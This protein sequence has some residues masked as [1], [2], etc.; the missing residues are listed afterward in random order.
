MGWL[1]HITT[2]GCAM[3][4][5]DSQRLASR[6]NELG[7]SAT[8]QRSQ[9][10]LA[11]LVT[12]GVRQSAEDRIYGLIKRIKQDNPQTAVALTGCLSYRPDIQAKIGQQVDYWFTINQLTELEQIIPSPQPASSLTHLHDYLQIKP[13]YTSKISALVPIGNGCDNFCSYCVVPYARGREKYRPADEIIAEVQN[14]LAADSQEITIIAQNVNSYRDP[15]SGLNF[16]GLLEQLDSLG[17]YWLRFA[18]SHPKDMSDELIAFMGRSRNLIHHLHLPVQSG[19]DRILQLMNRRYTSDHYRQ[20]I[21]A[22]RQVWPDVSLTTDIIVGFPGETDTDFQATAKLVTAS[23][24]DQVY[25]AQFSPRPGTA[26]A[27]LPDDVPTA[28]KKQR[29]I[30]LDQLVKAGTL[31]NRQAQIG[32]TVEVLLEEQRGH[33]YFGRTNRNQQILLI[34]QTGNNYVLGQRYLAQV[35]AARNFSLAGQLL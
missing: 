29:A 2:I 25:I 17:N 22:V 5:S 24:F 7:W 21:A 20:L 18:T 26:A 9:A 1:Y 14:L 31:S 35:T 30:D 34:P 13:L 10:D 4:I 32:Q 15:V 33:K 19:S 16:T 28:T 11:I 12:C 8:N 23:G 6:L 27:K 3:N